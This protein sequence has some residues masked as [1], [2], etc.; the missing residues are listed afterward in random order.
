MRNLN[1]IHRGVKN[2]D[3]GGGPCCMNNNTISEAKE[4]HLLNDKKR[5]DESTPKYLKWEIL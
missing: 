4:H 5:S 2:G 3:I 1:D